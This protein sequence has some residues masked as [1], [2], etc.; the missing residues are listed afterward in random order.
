MVACVVLMFFFFFSGIF[1]A[2]LVANTIVVNDFTLAIA[3]GFS[4]LMANR[5]IEKEIK[6][7]E[8]EGSDEDIVLYFKNE[9]PSVLETECKKRGGYVIPIALIAIG[10]TF[11]NN[12]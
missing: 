9:I 6:K 3:K 4:S 1:L 11:S 2:R 12:S 7:I 10:I 5:D 8:K